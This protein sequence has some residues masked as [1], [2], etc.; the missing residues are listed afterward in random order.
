MSSELNSLILVYF[1]SLIPKMSMFTLAH[2][3]DFTMSNLPW[4]FFTALN[5]TF[6]IRHIQN[7][8]SFLL[9]TSLFILSGAIIL[10]LALP[11]SILDTFQLGGCILWCHFFSFSYSSWGSCGKNTGVV[12]CFLL[13]WTT[14]CQNSSLWFVRL[15]W[16]CMARLIALLS[17]TSPIAT[18]RLW[19][20][21]KIMSLKSI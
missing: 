3:S 14:F 10:P 15:G 2:I 20:M 19:S 16:P 12:C 8:A 21:K 11:S 6:T 4:L 7:W 9:W 13:Q 1:S 5:F 18:T 17:Y